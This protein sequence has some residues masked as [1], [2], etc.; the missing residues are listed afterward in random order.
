MTVSGDSHN[1]WFANLTT[2]AGER[3]GWEF[4]GSSVSSPG[5][6]SVG[7]GTLAPVLD[8]S[9]SA[10]QLGPAAVGAG[11]GLVDDLVWADTVR[12]GW[13]SLTVTAASIR[14]DY[15][16]VD[17]VKSQTYAVTTGRT[18]TVQASGMV[19]VT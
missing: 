13:L 10:A 11:L 5:F 15:Q 4:A 19:A 18:V 14:G 8:G 7:L 17:T 9:V 2:L 1:A 3:V 16:F 6:E 12:R